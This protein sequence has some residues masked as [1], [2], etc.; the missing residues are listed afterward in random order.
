VCTHFETGDFKNYDRVMAFGEDKDLIT[1]EIEHVNLQALKDLK[2]GGKI[3]HPNPS[4][5]E[6]IQ[7]K[8]L[9][10]IFYRDNGFPTAPF[11]LFEDENALREAI[12]V[13][14][15]KLPLVQKTRTA[16]YDGKGVS[17]LRRES[18]LT[19]KLLSGPCLVE[20]MADM[21]KEIALIVARNADGAIRCFPPVEMEFH[22][23]ANLV[24][25]LFCP[26]D[27]S[28]LTIAT[29]DVL[30]ERLI[31]S[32]EVCGLLAVEMFLT[33]SGEIWINEV[34]PRPHNSGHHTMDSAVTSQFEQHLRGICNLPLGDTRILQPSVMVNLLGEPTFEGPVRYEG[35]EECLALSGVHI[36]LYSKT[37]TKPMRK[38]GHVTITAPTLKEAREKSTFVRDTLKVKSVRQ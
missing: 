36:H 9:Q 3:I 19:D 16:G 1:V 20:A 14:R 35:V 2:A 12:L 24:E 23:E 6:I 27:I 26:A 31:E 25:C 4:A 29:A 10:K 17:I 32:L 13:G 11:E 38:M 30:A 22:A 33:R 28:P 15:W 18:D 37:N 34:A 7:D 21:D 8:G 5:L